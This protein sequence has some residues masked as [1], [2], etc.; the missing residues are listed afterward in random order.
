MGFV[1]REPITASNRYSSSSALI[2]ADCVQVV[3]VLSIQNLA[4]TSLTRITCPTTE[5]TIN[6][7]ETAHRTHLASVIPPTRVPFGRQGWRLS[8]QLVGALDCFCPPS[9]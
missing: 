9:L 6:L 4:R 3:R 1:H 5:A 7:I 2:V 8:E